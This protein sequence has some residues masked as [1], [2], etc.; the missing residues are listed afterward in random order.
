M[1]LLHRLVRADHPAIP[2]SLDGEPCEGR[3]GD[4]VLTAILTQAERLRLSASSRPRRA[5]ASARWVPARIAGSCSKAAKAPAC[6]LDRANRRHAHPHPPREGGMNGHST[7]E[8]PRPLIVGAGPAGIR[9]AEALVAAGLRPLVVDEAPACGGQIYRQRLVPDGRSSTRPLRLGSAQRPRR[10]IATSLRSTASS[11]TGRRRCCGTCAMASADIMVE[12]TSRQ[13]AYD[14]LL[15]A[16][17]ATDRILPIP[18]WTLPGVFTLG[19]AQIA[20]KSQGCAIGS[21]DRL[22]RLRAAALSCRLAVPEGR[23]QGRGG[24]RHRALLGQV[25][26]AARPAALPGDRS[27]RHADDCR[28]E[29]RRRRPALRRH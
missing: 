21:K 26:P 6:L 17:G 25:Q 8:R 3:T 10:C 12:G 16:T 29:A 18:G 15:L 5:P 7:S 2:F 24:A 1:P 14:G 23:R 11:T 27:A 13:V 4:T 19:G 28:S 22:P 9:A 20:L